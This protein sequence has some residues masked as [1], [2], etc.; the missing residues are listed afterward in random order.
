[1]SEWME[2]YKHADR[3]LKGFARLEGAL[4]A[5]RILKEGQA[6]EYDRLLWSMADEIIKEVE[7]AGL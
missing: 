6:D 5:H 3:W 1:M 7:D 4:E 2:G